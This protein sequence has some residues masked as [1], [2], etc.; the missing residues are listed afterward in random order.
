M[1]G[2]RAAQKSSERTLALTILGV[3]TAASLASLAGD[4]WIVRAGVLV[5][6]VMAFA[7][8]WSPGAS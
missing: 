1:A 8:V 6:V 2:R 3:G 5:A 7:A 4:V